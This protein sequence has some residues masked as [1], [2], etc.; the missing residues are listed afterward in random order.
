MTDPDTAGPNDAIAKRPSQIGRY[1]V[2]KVLGHG[3][4][5]VVYLAR[6]EHLQRLVAIKVPH[7]RLLTAAYLTE[8]RRTVILNHPHIA[9]VHDVGTTAEYP[10]YIASKYIK[11]NN[12]REYWF[13]ENPTPAQSAQIVVTLAE[14]LGFAH[15]RGVCHLSLRP[16]K[17]VVDSGNEPWLLGDDFMRV[18]K[19]A[20]D[21]WIRGN[22][23][24]LS[25]EQVA[26]EADLIGPSSDIF[27]L[28]LVF[29]EMLTGRR[30]YRAE[31]GVEL[32]EEML[33]G[34]IEPPSRARSGIPS[35]FDTICGI[36]LAKSP[37]ARYQ[38]MADFADAL[39][40]AGLR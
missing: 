3:S 11:G 29:Y 30:P 27:S 4:L 21:L 10:C 40:K 31:G 14:A 5:G 33:H 19:L 20:G 7:P 2:E 18:E 22:P 9:P 28:G 8:V 32:C 13:A 36:A 25:P 6:D 38:N 34:G 39:R 15:V 16:G 35:E 26:G 17:I 24:Y 23:S 12:L 1:R 37:G